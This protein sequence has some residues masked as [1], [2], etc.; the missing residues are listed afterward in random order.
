[1]LATLLAAAVLLQPSAG[2]AQRAAT[3]QEAQAMAGE[4]GIIVFCYGPDWNQRSVRM[5]ETFWKNAATEE[6]AGNAVMV[7]VPYFQNPKSE[8]AQKFANER[9]SLPEP[10][11]GVC[12]AVL[13]YDSEG[14]NY[15]TLAGMD[16]FGDEEGKLGA[17]NIAKK[18]AELRTQRALISKA[19][20]ASGVERAKV[21]GEVMNLGIKA[22]K[23]IINE[24]E[25]ADPE[26][27][28]GMVR[29]NKHDAFYGF[30]YE[31]LQTKDGFLK[32]DFV[33]D[34]KTIGAACKK[35]YDDESY[36]P[37]DR[38]AA[39]ALLIGL[40]RAAGVPTNQLR[41]YITKCMKIDE[42]SV[43][44]RMCPAL[45]EKWVGGSSGGGGG[46]ASAKK[47]TAEERKAEREA[48]RES[49]K[50]E[51]ERKKQERKAARENKD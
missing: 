29:R 2:A 36:R 5:C 47:K 15:A 16:D 14:N 12:P 21:L 44:G 49:A 33:P 13:M 45:L 26:D 32:S 10:P 51:R 34:L 19:A 9:G 11:F 22:P 24:I 48:K 27:K 20:S 8:L 35:V 50:A 46:G 1:M 42:N 18:L 17:E 6:A 28:S 39:Y 43:Y 30:M 38:Q 4:D 37:E 3:Y 25:I 40:S 41:G 7:A 31:Q 23:G